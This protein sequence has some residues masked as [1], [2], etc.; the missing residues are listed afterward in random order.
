VRRDPPRSKERKELMAKDKDLSSYRER[1]TEQSGKVAEDV[2]ELGNIALEG[3]GEAIKDV[4]RRG[5]EA[6]EEGKER[7]QQRANEL[8][9]YILEHPFKAVCIA[10]GVGLLFGLLYRR[11]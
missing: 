10:A 3:A 1:L 4:R 9:E 2:K 11:P 6:A 8:E 7:V 5:R